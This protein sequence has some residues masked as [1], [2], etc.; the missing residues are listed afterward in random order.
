MVYLWA[1][2]EEDHFGNTVQSLLRLS[3]KGL[4]SDTNPIITLRALGDSTVDELAF[5]ELCF[6]HR[7]ESRAAVSSAWLFL[8]RFLLDVLL[9]ME[10]IYRKIVS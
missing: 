3:Q 4:F 2:K 5:P 7:W 9:L 8:L 6:H 1:L 10:I